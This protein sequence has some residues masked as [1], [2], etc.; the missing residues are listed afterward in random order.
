MPLA[1]EAKRLAE[2]ICIEKLNEQWAGI[3]HEKLLNQSF[4]DQLNSLQILEQLSPLELAKQHLL[5]DIMDILECLEKANNIPFNQL[6]YIM[7]NCADHYYSKVIE[8]FVAII[9]RQFANRQ[10]LL[11]NTAHSLKFL[12]EYSDRQAQIWK[13]F[14]KHHNIPDD[15]EDLHLHFDDFKTSLEIEFKHLKEAT[16]CNIQN[17]QTSISVQQTY[18]STLCSHINNIY[19]KLSEL[20]KLIQHCCMSSNQGKSVQTEAP[21]FDPDIDGDSPDKYTALLQQELQNPYWNLHHPISTKSYQISKDMDIETMPH[22]MYFTGDVDT[23]TKINHIPYQTI[24]YND[25]G[26]FTAKLMDNTPIKIFI[27]NGATPSILPT[28]TYNKFP[29]LHKYPRTESKTPIHTGGGLIKSHFWLEIPLK[30]NHQTIQIKAL[31][32]DS[33]CP[34]NLILG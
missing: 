23:V 8:A 15:L 16:S 6:Y 13:I 24:A 32:C 17:L 3:P 26:M 11:V 1:E 9:K 12:E 31:V 33:E 21:N 30:L 7:E 19:S 10:L 14:H 18:S 4:W 20:Q 2:E 27:D 5:A 25:N 29:I 28:H 34:Y 22:A